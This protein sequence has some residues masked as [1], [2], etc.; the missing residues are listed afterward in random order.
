M[1]ENT[2]LSTQKTEA[3]RV[4]EF[5]VSLI[6]RPLPQ[7]EEG[8]KDRNLILTNISTKMLFGGEQVEVIKVW[9]GNIN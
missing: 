8:G 9:T 5:K 4:C 3:V 7:R 6:V 1:G 2:Y